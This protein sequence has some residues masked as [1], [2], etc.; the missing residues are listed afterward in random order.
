MEVGI[1]IGKGIILA[2]VLG[3]LFLFIRGRI[4]ASRNKGGSPEKTPRGRS[5]K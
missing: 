4:A 5:Q 3:G 1:V 2:L